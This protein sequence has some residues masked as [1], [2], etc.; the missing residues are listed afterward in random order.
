MLDRMALPRAHALAALLALA[1]GDPAPAAEPVDERVEEG[2]SPP[3]L[4]WKPGPL[5]TPV[6]DALAEIDVPEGYVFL[7]Q[8][9]TAKLLELMQNPVS[10][11]ELAT[12][13][14]ASENESWLLFFEWDP[15]G[16]VDDSDKD[17]LD[18]DALLASLQEGTRAAN[19]ERKSRGWSTVEIV[20]WQEKPHYDEKTRNLTWAI[21]GSSDGHV[22]LN[23]MVK[24]LGRRGVMT[25]TAVTSPEEIATAAAA[26][27]A[28]LGGYRFRPG[29]TYAEYVPGKDKLAS[30]GLTALVAGGIG[31]AA[32]KS[33]LLGKFWKV[34]VVAAAGGTAWLRRLFTGRKHIADPP[35][36][37]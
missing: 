37:G 21:E 35:T 9:D 25:V 34:L 4:A 36:P 23:R 18:A 7:D 17:D 33:G 11:S 30:Y 8:A 3:Q 28:L 14:S 27:D 19:E 20:G 26:T 16:W 5:T 1:F 24:L 15:I 22:V 2:A 29:S 13:A 10:G 6:G 32:V 12:L 31:A